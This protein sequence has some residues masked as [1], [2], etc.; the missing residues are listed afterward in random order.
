MSE[1]EVFISTP[2]VIV[3]R[4][5]E[6]DAPA[7]AAYRGDPEVARYQG[8]TEFSEGDALNFI[9]EMRAGRPGVPGEWYQFALGSQPDGGLIGDIGFKVRAGDPSLADIGY[10]LARAHQGQ[11][12]ASEAV[13]AV[14]E[15]AFARLGVECVYATIDERNVASLALARRL[16][17]R[18]VEVVETEWRGEP[19]V[20]RVFALRRA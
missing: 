10:T 8:W 15:F 5:C 18:E 6:A 14:I 17:M 12:L 19:C 1:D 4:F 16:G 13:T 9:I 7:F 3:R 2:R 11:G 20:E